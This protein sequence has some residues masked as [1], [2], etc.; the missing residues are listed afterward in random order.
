MKPSDSWSKAR[1]TAGIALVTAACWLIVAM[2]GLDDMAARWGGFVPARAALPDDGSVAPFWITPLTA[3]L[4]HA[5]IIH[6]GFNLLILVFCGRRVENVLGPV[7][8]A[9]LYL[10]GAYAA[11]GAQYLAD[12]YSFVVMIGASGAISAVLGAYAMLFG[13]N[14]VSVVSGRLA[15]WLNALWLMTAWVIL[16]VLVGI[17][18]AQGAF[19]FTGK[20]MAIAAA[21]HI[22]GF[23]VGVILANPLFRFR[24]RNA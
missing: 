13:R 23:I 7:S 15:V 8:L 21:A 4:V 5:N 3:T 1:V 9:I 19:P 6:L 10:L 16:Q 18:S 2:L 11:A 14:R 24:W 20:G 12:P 17:A 22:G